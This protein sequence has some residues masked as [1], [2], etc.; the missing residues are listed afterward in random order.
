M[1]PVG[2]SSRPAI[3]PCAGVGHG[4]DVTLSP[5]PAPSRRPA[6]PSVS[7]IPRA[8][9]ARGAFGPSRRSEPG[10]TST[11][12][13]AGASLPVSP[14]GEGLSAP[15]RLAARSGDCRPIV[16]DGGSATDARPVGV[17]DDGS[18]MPWPAGFPYLPTFD[19]VSV[20]GTHESVGR[21]AEL[22]DFIRRRDPLP[23]SVGVN[24]GPGPG[25]ALKVVD[26]IAW[27]ICR[28]SSLSMQACR[29]VGAMRLSVPSM[30]T[31]WRLT[32]WRPGASAPASSAGAV[33]SMRQR[34]SSSPPISGVA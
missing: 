2:F 26:A 17:R 13:S 31:K 20:E 24:C 4:L 16:C 25:L 5:C 33:A 1:Q 12:K 19:P 30:S 3:G 8:A 28:R 22:A 27:S 21:F 15:D 29:T 14:I 23:A 10:W 6:S 18:L 32:R 7:S 9:Y 11:R 34:S